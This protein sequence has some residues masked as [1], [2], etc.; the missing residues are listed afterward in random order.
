VRSD[1]ASH[2]DGWRLPIEP[3]NRHGLRAALGQAANFVGHHSKDRP[4]SLARA[5]STLAVS[6]RMLLWS[7]VPS[8]APMKSLT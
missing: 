2:S 3:E 6:A 5:A 4:R 1:Q 8:I 7:A